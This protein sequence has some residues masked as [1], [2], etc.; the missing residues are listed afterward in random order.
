M[1][2]LLAIVSVF[3]VLFFAPC[4][5]SAEDSPNP[6]KPTPQQQT[7]DRPAQ[8]QADATP[9][10]ARREEV[11]EAQ[12]RASRIDKMAAYFRSKGGLAD[13]IAA[14]TAR[15][16]KAESELATAREQLAALKTENER[17]KADWKAL[18]EAALAPGET[19][20]EAS[21]K[22]AAVINAQVG[23]ELRSIG[24]VPKQTKTGA[25]KEKNDSAAQERPLTALQLIALGRQKAH[26]N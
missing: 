26:L 2:R 19:K 1:N 15:A 4:A 14:A 21:Y 5:A 24:H 17:L 11:D 12:E 18:E 3:A 13:S 16:E 22:A 7:P 8:G 10:A 6:D 9:K 23:K 20:T 25:D